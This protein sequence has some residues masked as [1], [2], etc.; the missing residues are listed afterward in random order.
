MIRIGPKKRIVHALIEK[1]PLLPGG[2]WRQGYGNLPSFPVHGPPEITYKSGVAFPILRK[3]IFKV[4]IHA[5]IALF[6]YGFQQ[7]FNQNLLHLRILGNRF[8]QLVIK[9]ALL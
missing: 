3:N 5:G 7:V 9:I 1:S 8:Y 2:F 4:Y 6:S